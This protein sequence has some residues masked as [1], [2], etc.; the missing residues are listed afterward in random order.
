ML[1]TS[2]TL[3]SNPDDLKPKSDA[4]KYETIDVLVGEIPK[5]YSE[6]FLKIKLRQLDSELYLKEIDLASSQKRESKHNPLSWRYRV[7][8]MNTKQNGSQGNIK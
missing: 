4:D 1:I 5:V 7:E 8:A 3:L 6:L 2:R